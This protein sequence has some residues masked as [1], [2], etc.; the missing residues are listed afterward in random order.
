MVGD[1]F[2]SQKPPQPPAFSVQ[3]EVWGCLDT[4]PSPRLCGGMGVPGMFLS[5]VFTVH[6]SS[7]VNVLTIVCCSE[8]QANQRVPSQWRCFSRFILG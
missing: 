8:V 6:A 4:L 1:L 2:V 5:A 7:L 3:P